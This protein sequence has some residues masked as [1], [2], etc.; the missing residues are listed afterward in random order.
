MQP[1]PRVETSSLLLPS[2]RF[3]ICVSS[4]M[5]EGGVYS[6]ADGRK[7]TGK[8]SKPETELHPYR[9]W[10]HAQHPFRHERHRRRRAVFVREVVGKEHRGPSIAGSDREA[11]ARDEQRIATDHGGTGVAAAMFLLRG[12]VGGC[13]KYAPQPAAA[14]REFILAQGAGGELRRI[15]EAIALL[16]EDAARYGHRFVER[17]VVPAP[18]DAEVKPVDRPEVKAQ[19]DADAARGLAVHVGDERHALEE[20]GQ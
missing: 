20:H 12:V 19:V 15:V 17:Q 10:P 1:S 16:E 13:C 11:R 5:A 18:M 4:S 2:L 14:E 7:V 3:C 9:P 6:V 8:E